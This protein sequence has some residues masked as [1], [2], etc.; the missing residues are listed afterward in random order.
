LAKVSKT[1]EF[2]ESC[3]GFFPKYIPFLVPGTR[4]FLLVSMKEEG[5]EIHV[6]YLTRH[7]RV[8]SLYFRMITAYSS[9]TGNKGDARY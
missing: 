9:R 4:E 6:E 5:W 2:G 7:Y 3:D 1:A 8:L